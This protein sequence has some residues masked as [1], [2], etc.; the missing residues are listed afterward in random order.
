MR[1]VSY[2]R[3]RDMLPREIKQD[4]RRA[5]LKSLEPRAR[6]GEGGSR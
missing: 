6:G 4:R 5:Y 2:V 1:N 3:F